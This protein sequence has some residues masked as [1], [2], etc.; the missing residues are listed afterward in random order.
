MKNFT[1][2]QSAIFVKNSVTELLVP[3]LQEIAERLPEKKTFATFTN[4]LNY[5]DTNL[6]RDFAIAEL[7]DLSGM[8]QAEFSAAFRKVFGLPPKQYI[9][10]RR[11]NRAKYL[12]LKTNLPIKKIARQ[13]GY[14]DEYFFHKI[15]KK[16]TEFSPAHYRK[17]S[18][19]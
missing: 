15:F 7:N 10:M 3:F 5:I 17:Y 13:C 2:L 6:H 16:Y 11:I 1:D 8:R 14:R 19:H 4:I 9:S 18:V 12:L